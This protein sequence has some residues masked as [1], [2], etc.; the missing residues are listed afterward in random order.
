MQ[1]Y[2][3]NGRFLGS[4]NIGAEI[5]KGP[6]SANIGPF[7]TS[8]PD[9]ERESYSLVLILGTFFVWK[10]RIKATR[11]KR[12]FHTFFWVRKNREKRTK[13]DC[14]RH[15]KKCQKNFQ[16]FPLENGI[17][18]LWNQISLGK[19][20]ISAIFLAQIGQ[21]SNFQSKRIEKYAFQKMPFKPF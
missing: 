1:L 14:V 13:N 5:W 9:F 7:G 3:K 18:P 19:S 10:R 2:P 21:K 6:S 16:N 17:F 20:A 8:R 11:A 12:G 15:V 4:F